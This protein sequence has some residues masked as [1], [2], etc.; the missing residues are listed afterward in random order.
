MPLSKH[1]ISRKYNRALT[2]QELRR[3]L[4]K[5]KTTYSSY[6]HGFSCLLDVVCEFEIRQQQQHSSTAIFP[7]RSRGGEAAR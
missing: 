6:Q 3:M 5:I 7:T 4:S 1:G 2:Y